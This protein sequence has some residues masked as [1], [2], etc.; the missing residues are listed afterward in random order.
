M[1]IVT[2]P[3]A[4]ATG[5]L[6]GRDSPI[7]SGAAPLVGP[8]ISAGLPDQVLLPRVAL[9][10]DDRDLHQ[11]I[12]DLAAGGHFTL[13]DS[14]YTAAEALE[15]LPS[16]RPD[17]VIMD[18]RLPDLSGIECTAKLKTILPDLPV[19]ILTGFPDSP[20][21][22]RSLIE[23]AQGFLFKPLSP[24]EFL[25]AIAQVM[26]GEFA[27]ARQVVPYL[28]QLVRQLRQVDPDRLLTQRE[29]DILACLFEGMQNKEIAARLGIGSATVH[30]HIHS[31]FEKLDVHS[32][33]E[34]I[35]R[36]LGRIKPEP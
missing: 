18:I 25:D 24:E 21:F 12:R 5:F 16:L 22:F 33:R 20:T 8:A 27:L 30:T 17:V 13:A 10:D 3:T 26:K 28:I 14:Y 34:L 35:S 31:L 11:M 9:V 19:V 15:G 4:P 23:G 2:E 6:P 36:F 7:E 32:R 29:E 1:Q